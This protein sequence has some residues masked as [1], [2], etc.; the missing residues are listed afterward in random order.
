MFLH[1]SFINTDYFF[2]LSKRR[3]RLQT[4]ILSCT[5]SQNPVGI[6]QELVK[7]WIVGTYVKI[8]SLC[9]RRLHSNQILSGL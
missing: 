3:C 2:I 7:V 8:Y 1:T 4:E 6:K 9:K 5:D